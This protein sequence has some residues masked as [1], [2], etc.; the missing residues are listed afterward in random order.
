MIKILRVILFFIVFAGVSCHEDENS[1]KSWL[2]KYISS[3]I[4]YTVYNEVSVVH[5]TKINFE[6][7]K[8]KLAEIAKNHNLT[9][10]PDAE[11][12]I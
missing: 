3:P 9:F 11:Y 4:E 5:N 1:V 2:G 8:T 6:D 10:S 7:F 12:P